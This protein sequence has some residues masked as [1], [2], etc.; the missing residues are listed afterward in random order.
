MDIKKL[1]VLT[2]VL[3]S[4][5]L[6]NSYAGAMGPVNVANTPSVYFISGEGLYTWKTIGP[7]MQN[8]TLVP[9]NS[10]HWGG[11]VAAGIMKPY[12]DVRFSVE[13]GWGMYGEDRYVNPAVGVNRYGRAYGF[14]LLLGTVYTYNQFDVFLKAG[15]F[16]E[17]LQ[18]SIGQNLAAQ[19]PGGASIGVSNIASTQTAILPELKI[20]GI[21]NINDSLGISLAYMYVFGSRLQWNLNQAADPSQYIQTG[22]QNNQL[23]AFGALALGINYKFND[24]VA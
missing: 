8:G 23:P 14:D 19:K 11:R 7:L 5:L 24:D 18:L 1:A 12:K 21:Y 2:T 13:A 22:T 20:G 17:N 9:V 3:S 10:Q 6:P 16:L 4:S 15:A